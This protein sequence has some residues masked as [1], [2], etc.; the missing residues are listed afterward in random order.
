M[1][2]KHKLSWQEIQQFQN[3]Q[4]EAI[5][6]LTGRYGRVAELNLLGQNLTILIEPEIIHQFLLKK[7]AQLKRDPFTYRVTKRLAGEGVFSAEGAIWQRKRKLIAPIFHAVHIQRFADEFVRQT[8]RMINDWQDHQTLDFDDEMMQLT[9]RTI[10]QTMFGSNIDEHIPTIRDLLHIMMEEAEAQLRPPLPDWFP[11]FG[12][13][14]QKRAANRLRPLFLRLIRERQE[15]LKGLSEEEIVQGEI[16]LLTMLIM[17]RDEA[18]Q[19]LSDEEVLD[20]CLTIFIA[21][22]ETTA[23]ASTWTTALLLQHPDV[24]N[25]L[26]NELNIGLGDA[27]FTVEG[28]RDRCRI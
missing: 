5:M 28:L 22:H 7:S 14:R 6:D 19:P 16:D 10:S 17:A 12:L 8:E 9:L 27:P 26:L 4:V 15:A 25:R 20:E 23:I 3:N 13:L 21:G 1:G 24:L 11:T 2:A 18:G